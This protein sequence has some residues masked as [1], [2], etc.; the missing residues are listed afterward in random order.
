MLVARIFASLAGRPASLLA[1]A[2]FDMTRRIFEGVDPFNALR[3]AA[4][5]P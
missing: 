4:R 1:G 2:P 3:T 5:A